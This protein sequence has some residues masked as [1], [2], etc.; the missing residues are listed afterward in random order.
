MEVFSAIS[1]ETLHRIFGWSNDDIRQ[2]VM[3]E[4]DI[5]Y[6]K[7]KTVSD[8]DNGEHR[9]MFLGIAQNMF[10]RIQKDA[11][12]EIQT[13]NPFIQ[14]IRNLSSSTQFRH[15]VTGKLSRYPTGTTK[16]YKGTL[17]RYISYIVT[18]YGMYSGAYGGVY[19]FVMYKDR[20]CVLK[21]IE[22]SLK[23]TFADFDVHPYGNSKDIFELITQIYLY[24]ALTMSEDYWSQ[25]IAV[26][27]VMYVQR[28]SGSNALHVCM[29]RSDATFMTN[30][31]FEHIFI[32]LAHVFKT[33]WYLQ[34]RF[35]FM[36]RDF[37]GNNVAYDIVNHVVHLIDFGMSC[38]NPSHDNNSFA[39]QA[40]SEDVRFYPPIDGS[41][42]SMCTNRS[43]DACVILL[44]VY[45]EISRRRMSEKKYP[46]L[47]SFLVKEKNSIKQHIT[48]IVKQDLEKRAAMN[49]APP[50][51]AEYTNFNNFRD[52]DWVV[53][54]DDT[55]P[56]QYFYMY[57]MVEYPCEHFYPE[58]IL[59][60]MIPYLS[61]E[62]IMLLREGWETTFDA[63]GT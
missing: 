29:E 60:R 38:I 59:A 53:G 18:G 28:V 49:I 19:P 63:I 3:L 16:V 12:K 34:K 8:L 4:S 2:G 32:A 25:H 62:D 43:L 24:Q 37:H 9:K 41:Q 21:I 27:E 52:D 11:I 35:H 31:P 61:V 22:E 50:T 45:A 13:H 23:V 15:K 39:W 1:P 10:R 26:P 51:N 57:D 40:Y 55:S 42:A 14:W 56:G 44:S 36:H 47:K 33:L 5:Y 46:F 20:T 54:N 58:N 48:K 17:G 7:I 6:S 30:M